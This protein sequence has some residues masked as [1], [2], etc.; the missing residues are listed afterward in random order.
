M[1]SKEKKQEIMN[2]YDGDMTTHDISIKV[3]VSEPTICKILRMGGFPKCRRCGVQLKG[4]RLSIRYCETCRRIV[5]NEAVM[6]CYKRKRSL[7]LPIDKNG[8]LLNLSMGELSTH[9]DIYSINI[10][11]LGTSNLGTKYNSKE[12]EYTAIIREHK[13]LLGGYEGGCEDEDEE[14]FFIRG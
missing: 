5:S 13:R 6:D 3:K 4:K 10:G 8:D 1:I 14:S 9:G 11:S 7:Q 2:L 12:E